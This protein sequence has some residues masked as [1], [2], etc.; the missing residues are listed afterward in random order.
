MPQVDKKS[1]LLRQWEML[2]LVPSGGSPWVKASEVAS[3]LKDA[4]YEVSVRTVQRDLKEL[5][6]VF[7]IELN[8]KNLRDYGWRWM[9]GTHLNVPGLSA[10]EALAMRLVETHLKQLLP[11]SM[12]E[13]LRGVFGQA[14]SRLE[15]T[16]GQNGSQ[17]AGWL[18]KVKVVQPTQPLIPP[19]VDKTAQD[20]IYLGLLE[21]RQLS[22]SYHSIGGEESRE[23]VLHPLGLVMRGSV[24]YLIASAWD[25]DDVRMYALHRFEKAE[26][27]IDAVRVPEGFDLEKSI[28]SGF[29]DFSN[30]EEP[31][32]LEILC[33]DSQAAYLAETPLSPDQK[34]EPDEEGW[35]RLSATVNDTW[36]LRWWLLSQ[37]ASIEVLA[38]ESLRAGI[39]KSLEEALSNYREG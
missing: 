9:R 8:D 2:K 23:Y 27:S 15:N 33:E 6:T 17:P 26:V 35:V 37:G 22:A 1:T 29:A 12:L 18:N 31:I 24:S 34:I 10:S 25:Y 20:A 21:N 32:R 38:P 14:K 16:A 28:A 5:S 13:A 30:Q 19:K 3:K 36:Q 39:A 11:S 7:P 4:G